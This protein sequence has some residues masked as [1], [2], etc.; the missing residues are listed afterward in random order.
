MHGGFVRFAF[1]HREDYW[2]SYYFSRIVTVFDYI[3]CTR[4][5][6]YNKEKWHELLVWQGRP[7]WWRPCRGPIRGL[8]ECGFTLMHQLNDWNLYSIIHIVTPRKRALYWSLHWRTSTWLF[9]QWDVTLLGTL[10]GI[11]GK[12]RG[13]FVIPD[14]LYQLILQVALHGLFTKE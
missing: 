8:N 11:P 10:P 2:M 5:M 6:Q 7:H 1:V 4:F 12:A 14:A 13:V 3:L 9:L